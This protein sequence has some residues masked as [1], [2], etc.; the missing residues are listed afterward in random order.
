MQHDDMP[1]LPNVNPEPTIRALVNRGE[2]IAWGIAAFLAAGWSVSA[3]WPRLFP[4]PPAEVYLPV[5][6]NERGQAKLPT[7]LAEETLDPRLVRER[8]DL[9]RFVVA[10]HSYSY[11]VLPRDYF[12]VSCMAPDTVFRQYEAQFNDKAAEGYIE[13]EGVKDRVVRTARA[14]DIVPLGDNQSG[15]A[16]DARI[17]LERTTRYK[18]RAASDQPKPQYFVLTVSYR[19]DPKLKLSPECRLENELGI[20][21]TSIRSDQ[22]LEA[23]PAAVTRPAIGGGA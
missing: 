1:T 18:D 2:R 5:Y 19:Y 4:Q 22:Q 10:F 14:V 7:Q 21:V 9:N 11:D 23:P 6:V 12:T 3:A 8:S 15:S 16:R 20:V 13:V 17:T